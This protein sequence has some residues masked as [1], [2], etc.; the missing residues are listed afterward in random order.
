LVTGCPFGAVNTRRT[1]FPSNT[2][3]P[4]FLTFWKT[5]NVR[6]FCKG[7]REKIWKREQSEGLVKKF[8]PLGTFDSDALAICW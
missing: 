1:F 2:G 8:V 6:E 5:E 3:S 7:G 4:L